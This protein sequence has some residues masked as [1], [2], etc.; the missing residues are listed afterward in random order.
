M[1][2]KAVIQTIPNFVMSCFM[3]A[4]GLCNGI[5][6]L[7]RKFW[8]GE[9]GGQRRIHWKSW[10]ILCKPKSDG[11][12]GFKDL[13]KFNKAMF[14]KQVWRLPTDKTS[15]F[16]KVFSTKYF[17][18]GSVFDAKSSKGSYVWRIILKARQVVQEG[19][20]WRIGDGSKIRVFHDKWIPGE[21]PLKAAAQNQEFVDDTTVSSLI[22]VETGEWNGQLI[23]QLIS[24]W[25]AQRIKA[26]PLCQTLQ[27]DCIVWPRSKDGNY[28]VKTGYQV[29][30][31]IERR[32]GQHQV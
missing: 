10:E 3:L 23:D 17:P 29:L 26:I 6:M 18:S 4:V 13:A 12:M 9:H 25:L 31:E 20:L 5:E 30:E 16:F 21:F 22:D 15:L 11:G 2:L 19:M 8:W 32:E 24:P 1:L 7:I 14:V 27:E 28:S